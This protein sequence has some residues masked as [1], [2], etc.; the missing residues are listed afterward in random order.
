MKKLRLDVETRE[1]TDGINTIVL[2]KK[3][4]KI[5]TTVATKN[6]YKEQF[7]GAYNSEG[8]PARNSFGANMCQA[9][10]MINN[11]GISFKY[12]MGE[13]GFVIK[14]EIILEN[15][16]ENIID[17]KEQLYSYIDELYKF[18]IIDIKEHKE[19]TNRVFKAVIE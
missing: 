17:K 16:S 11:A 18:G 12:E 13:N 7:M 9:S 6:T 2:T 5:I 3:K 1:L 4:C 14:N 8:G 10:A 19:Q 15:Y